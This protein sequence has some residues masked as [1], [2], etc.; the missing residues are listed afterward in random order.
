MINFPINPFN[1]IVIF[2]KFFWNMFINFYLG[3]VTAAGFL[4]LY[5]TGSKATEQ[6]DKKKVIAYPLILLLVYPVLPV[7]L[8]LVYLIKKGKS[9]FINL[10]RILKAVRFWQE[11]Y[12][13]NCFYHTCQNMTFPPLIVYWKHWKTND[14]FFSLTTLNLI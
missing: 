11:S 5:F 6:L 14:Y 12:N 1:L 2:S 9:C 4:Y 10:P 13:R 8:T 7:L 3:I